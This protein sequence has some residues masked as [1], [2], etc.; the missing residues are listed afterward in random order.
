MVPLF[1]QHRTHVSMTSANVCHD[2][3]DDMV[4]M[5]RHFVSLCGLCEVVDV[6]VCCCVCCEYQMAP[7]LNQHRPHVSMTSANACHDTND[8]MV[9]MKRHFVGLCGLCGVVDV[10]VCCCCV[11]LCVL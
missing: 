7:L 10:V 3:N 11:L 5:K 6:V 4:V 1:N 9:V 2:T 8:D